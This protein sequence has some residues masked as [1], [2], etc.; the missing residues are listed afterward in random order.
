VYPSAERRAFRVAEVEADPQ[1]TGAIKQRLRCRVGHFVLEEGI[2][3]S[4]LLHEPTWKEGGQRQFGKNDSMTTPRCGPFQQHDHSAD[5]G[6]ARLIPRDRT[7]LTGANDDFSAHFG[8]VP[9][10][11]SGEKVALWV[12]RVIENLSAAI[13]L[14]KPDIALAPPL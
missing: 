3:F 1:F 6:I 7:K 4:L 11:L 12:M 10:L 14:R 8:G 5:R 13:S 9:R 2:D